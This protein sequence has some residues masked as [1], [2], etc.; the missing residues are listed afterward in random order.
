MQI[1]RV[2]PVITGPGRNYVFVKIETDEGLYGWGEGTLLWSPAEVYTRLTDIAPRLVG[3]D[4]SRIEDIW[5]YL[6]ARTYWRG[7]SIMMS[8]LAAI[9]MALWDLQGKRTGQ[10]VYR[11]LGGKSREGVLVYTHAE[12]PTVEQVEE[13]VAGF[14]AQGFKAVRAQQGDYGGPGLGGQSY[15]GERDPGVEYFRPADYLETAPKMFARLRETFGPQVELLHD[16]HNKLTPIEASQLARRLEPFRLFFL[17]DPLRPEHRDSFRLLRQHS[18]TALAIGEISQSRWDLLQLFQEQLI[19]YYRLPPVHCGGITEAKKIAAMAEPYM[20]RSA[21]H[22]SDDMGPVAQAASVHVSRNIHNFGILEWTA[23]LP[24]VHEVV[25]GLCELRDGLAYP[26]EAPGLGIDVD[27]AAA[28]RFPYR[29]ED[30]PIVR[31]IDGTMHV[32]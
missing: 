29:P 8:A 27:E 17:E 22:G 25:S 11:L 16:A 24:Q 15:A 28:A 18:T 21:Y 13:Q 7:G 9:D 30:A 5:Q 10:P 14:L 6:Y 1:T 20:I 12:A 3:W 32:Y 26:R 4:S 23:F 2:T 31:R 19:D